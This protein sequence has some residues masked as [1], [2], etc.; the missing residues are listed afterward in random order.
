MLNDELI[1]AYLDGELDAEK[2]ALVEHWLASDSGAAARL[3]RM[4]EADALIRDAIPRVTTP[5]DDPIA[6]MIRGETS[7]K[8]LAFP[9][10][11]REWGVRAAALAAAC[12][13]GVLAGRMTAPALISLD[14]GVD[15]QMRVGPQVAQVLD[16]AL[17]GEPTPVLGGQVEVALSFHT[18]AGQVCRQYRTSAGGRATDAVACRDEQGWRMLV[19]AVAPEA[20]EGAFVTAGANTPLD[21]A[22]SALGP[23]SA[24]DA[25]EE[26]ALIDAHW[27]LAR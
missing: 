15:A 11:S 24:L 19:Q 10:V 8:V 22:I 5:A 21:A 27:R 3:E 4:R 18:E 7:G 12:V 14:R 13:L 26:R 23:A 1:G 2:R 16:T 9:R 17:S 25:R 6:A 20:Q